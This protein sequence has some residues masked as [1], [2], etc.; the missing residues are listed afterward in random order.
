MRERKHFVF[1]FILRCISFL[2]SDS[3]YALLSEAPYSTES[4]THRASLD[5]DGRF[6]LFWKLNSTH[7]TF[8]AHVKTH[9]YVGLG[10]SNSGRMFPA[11]VAV[12]WVTNGQ[13]YFQVKKNPATTTVKNNYRKINHQVRTNHRTDT[14]PSKIQEWTGTFPWPWKKQNT[15]RYI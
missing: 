1:V 7:V 4:F 2:Q 14:S 8:E 9:G 6:H 13:T 3:A 12:G 10:L 5:S 15:D 11:D